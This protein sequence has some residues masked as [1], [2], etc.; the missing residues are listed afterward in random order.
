MKND[1][2][3]LVFF[4]VLCVCVCMDL[5][6]CEFYDDFIFL[7]ILW[8]LNFENLIKFQRTQ[9]I[10][11]CKNL[12]QWSI[13]LNDTLFKVLI[14]FLYSSDSL[15]GSFNSARKNNELRTHGWNGQL[16]KTTVQLFAKS[17]KGL[18]ITNFLWKYLTAY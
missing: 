4:L 15:T 7:W 8:W 9:K 6:F 2:F 10:S 5:F 18:R 3:F 13:C 12:S 11:T 1:F 14:S 17:I 16:V